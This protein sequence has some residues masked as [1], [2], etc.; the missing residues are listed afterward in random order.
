MRDRPGAAPVGCMLLSVTSLLAK[1]VTSVAISCICSWC[2]EP[3]L[4]LR[5]LP[6]GRV[7]ILSEAAA[8]AT[9]AAAR[10][11]RIPIASLRAAQAQELREAAD[12]VV[13]VGSGTDMRAQQ[14]YVRL[15][16]V[17]G[18]TRVLLLEGGGGPQATLAV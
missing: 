17:Y 9:E 13:V 8:A 12:F 4:T 5:S 14:A 2:R 7:G 3:P 10:P 16:R 11:F 1:L 6:P 15:T 18:M